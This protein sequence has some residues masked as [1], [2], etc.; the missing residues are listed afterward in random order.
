MANTS[1]IILGILRSLNGHLQYIFDLDEC[2]LPSVGKELC[3][4]FCMCILQDGIIII[5]LDTQV[6]L[7]HFLH[8]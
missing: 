2:M 5:L 4:V 1:M 7:H 3:I 8:V 6:I